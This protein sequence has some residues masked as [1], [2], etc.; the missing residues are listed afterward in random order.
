MAA[1]GLHTLSERVSIPVTSSSPPDLQA[2]LSQDPWSKSGKYALGWVYFS[3][4]LLVF[5]IVIHLYHWMSDRIRR[6]TY[7]EEVAKSSATSSPDDNYEMA[8]LPTNS[9]TH[10]FFPRHGPIPQQ[11]QEEEETFLSFTPLNRLV[12]FLRY[13]FYRPLPVLRIRPVG[14]LHM[15]K[16]VISFPSPSVIFIATASIPARMARGGE[17]N[18]ILA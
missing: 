2:A 9:S 14:F 11:Q 16:R 3:I 15:R 10:M 6:A 1:E 4:I 8:N 7:K 5:T 13:F 17:P 18:C 12:A